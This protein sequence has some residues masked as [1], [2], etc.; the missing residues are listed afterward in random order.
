MSNRPSLK[1]EVQGQRPEATK[2]SV[3]KVT[4]HLGNL[5][6]RTRISRSTCLEIQLHDYGGRDA[7][8]YRVREREAAYA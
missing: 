4:P 1:P 3:I 8:K 7:E 6:P 5:A 2:I